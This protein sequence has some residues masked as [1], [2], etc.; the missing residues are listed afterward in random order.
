MFNCYL[1]KRGLTELRNG[2]NFLLIRQFGKQSASLVQEKT[3]KVRPSDE[4]RLRTDCNINPPPPC[5]NYTQSENCTSNTD[6]CFLEVTGKKYSEQEQQHKTESTNKYSLSSLTIFHPQQQVETAV[7][8]WRRSASFQLD[9]IFTQRD[10]KYL[11][12]L[13]LIPQ[14]GKKNRNGKGQ[15]FLRSM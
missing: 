3:N 5:L 1:C 6:S 12:V 2:G 8:C 9:F 14:T 13:F 15:Q 4:T 7:C 10:D 11:Y